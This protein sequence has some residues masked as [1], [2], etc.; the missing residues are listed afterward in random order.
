MRPLQLAV[1]GGGWAGLS[2][3]VEA[4]LNGHR[5]TLFE[6]AAHWGGRA[7]RV[8][9]D[10]L[11]LDNGQHIMIGAYRQTLRLMD[12]IGVDSARAFV[13]TPLRL[14]G[15]DGRGLTLPPGSAVPSFVR[16]VMAQRGWTLGERIALLSTA[17]GW[18]TRRFRCDERLT[19]AKLTARLPEKIRAELIDPLCVAALNT[20]ADEASA[21]VFLR[22][23]RDALFSGP[24]SADLLLPR[25]RLT[26]LL[27]GPAVRWLEAHGASLRPSTR[28]GHLEADNE[29]WTV[30]GQHFDAVVLATT[31][32]E[33]A[34]LAASLAPAWAAQAQALRYEPIVTVYAQADGAR[35]PQPM[36][37]LPSDD[38][39]LPAQFVFDHGQLGGR[40]GL[41]AFVIS[42]AQPWLDRGIDLTRDATLA[43][44]QQQLRAHLRGPLQAVRVLTE[45]RATFR[46][47]P[48][49]QRPPGHIAT[50]LHAAGD[51]VSGPYPATIEGAVRS[52]LEAVHA[53]SA[54]K[55]A[56]PAA[57][58]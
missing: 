34:R 5:V 14:A 45:K 56:P 16:G 30:N 7:R 46:C 13:R 11:A 33:A 53:L 49:L 44:G 15:A 9:L 54:W 41:M 10:G 23:M 38:R 26:E 4:S 35:L 12:I 3:A 28:V 29:G 55:T 47:V 6:M 21:A 52:A 51:Y 22:V 50:A 37:A 2:A 31:A 1:V 17:G 24:G 43:Q 36:L 20:P 32:V 40:A 18:A 8:D 57:P 39:S 25:S 27:P 58:R 48:Q 19:V 42:G